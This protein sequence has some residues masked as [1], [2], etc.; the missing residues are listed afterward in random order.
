V[1]EKHCWLAGNQPAEQGHKHCSA[2]FKT[3]FLITPPRES[4]TMLL[5][6]LAISMMQFILL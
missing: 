5:K 2:P 3:E 6:H 1:K 4:K